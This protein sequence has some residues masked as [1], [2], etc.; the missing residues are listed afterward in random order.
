MYSPETEKRKN[1]GLVW[2]EHVNWTILIKKS[3]NSYQV[4]FVEYISAIFDK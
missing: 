3:D 1:N 2:R 4:H